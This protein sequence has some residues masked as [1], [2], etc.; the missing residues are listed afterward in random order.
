VVEVQGS[1][2]GGAV[3]LKACGG[4]GAG[5]VGGSLGNLVFCLVDLLRC[6]AGFLL[7]L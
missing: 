2:V 7:T 1:I 6:W 3:I 5:E 4:A